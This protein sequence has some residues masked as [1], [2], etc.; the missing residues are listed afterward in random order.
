MKSIR[1]KLWF[2]MMILVGVILLL[3]WLFQIVFLEKFYSVIEIGEV[4]KQAKNIVLEIEDLT[5]IS[6]IINEDEILTKIDNFI[7]EKQVSIEIIDC[8]YNILYQESSSSKGNVPGIMQEVYLEISKMA[9]DGESSKQVV[10][11]P[12]YGYDFMIIGIP[13]NNGNSIEGVMLVTMPM[14]SISETGNIL[15]KQLV[16]ITVILFGAALFISYKLSK[17]FAD[18]ISSISKQVNSYAHGEYQVRVSQSSND[19]I[20]KLAMQMNEMGEALTRNEVLQKELISNV[21][22]ELRTPLTL[23]RGY[24][25][26]LRDITGEDKIKREKQLEIIIEESQRLGNIVEDILDLSRLQ[27]G[28]KTFKME[29]FSL[30]ELITSIKEKFELGENN[31]SIELDG[32]LEFEDNIIGDKSKIEQVFYNLI[33]NGFHHSKPEQPVILI[34]IPYETT[35][36]IQVK[37][38][39]EGIAE[40]D[41]SHVF[42]RYYRG[43][44]VD[45]NKSDGTGLGL[46]IVKSI[47][48]IHNVTYGVDSKLGEGTTFW[49]ELKRENNHTSF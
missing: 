38:Y 29:I 6:E 46:A 17:S 27:S 47:L 26:T 25:E 10:T 30:K 13:I 21:S 3:L 16:I 7:Y 8:D 9:I 40:E 28:T 39:G 14:A 5:S 34:V 2:G 24:A 44:R 4:N 45:N 37:D 12:K 11:H 19:E 20:G 35:V 22:H 49:F 18:P 41:I 48:D 32:V 33:S 31:R 15:K 36:K 1:S 42:E 43:K 23:I